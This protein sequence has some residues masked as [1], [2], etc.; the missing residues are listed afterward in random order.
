M[1]MGGGHCGILYG[2][3]ATRGLTQQSGTKG[4][5][6]QPIDNQPRPPLPPINVSTWFFTKLSPLL[7]R[8]FFLTRPKINDL[9]WNVLGLPLC[10]ICIVLRFYN[11]HHRVVFRRL[12]NSNRD[13]RCNLWCVYI[14]VFKMTDNCS[15][16]NLLSCVLKLVD[17]MQT[18]WRMN[19]FCSWV[20]VWHSVDYGKESLQSLVLHFANSSVM[21]FLRFV[22]TAF[23]AAKMILV[24]RVELVS[25]MAAA[26]ALFYS[27]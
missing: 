21:V 18:F 25:N 20:C 13:R 23:S 8:L 10:V 1:G 5:A 16:W 3:P 12:I 9:I 27:V 17:L 7:G 11:D 26:I 2:A 14:F 24:Y 22:M 15:I 19:S 4:A 6:R